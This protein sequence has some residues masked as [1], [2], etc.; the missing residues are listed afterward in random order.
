MTSEAEE[1]SQSAILRDQ[2]ID[3]PTSVAGRVEDGENL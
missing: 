1:G 3:R 2:S